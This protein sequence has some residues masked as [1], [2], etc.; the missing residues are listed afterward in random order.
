MV[1]ALPSSLVLL[2]LSALVP[3]AAFGAVD[4]AGQS[5]SP[6]DPFRALGG[7]RFGCWTCGESIDARAAKCKDVCSLEEEWEQGSL[8]E[9]EA[10]DD[11]WEGTSTAEMVSRHD[12]LDE[13]QQGQPI[14]STSTSTGA[15]QP[16]ASAD[17]TPSL[18]DQR[19]GGPTTSLA[20]STTPL[21]ASDDSFLSFEDWKALQL[22]KL[23]SDG[24]SAPAVNFPSSLVDGHPS[25]P[26]PVLPDP[27]ALNQSH[28]GRPSSPSSASS[29]SASSIAVKSLTPSPAVKSPSRRFNYA[30][31]D[32]SARIHFSSS[33]TRSPSAILHKSKDRYMLTPCAAKSHYV[34]IELCDEIRLDT[35]EVGNFEFFSSVVKD[36][37]VRAGESEG[38]GREDEEGWKDLGTFRM[39]NTRGMQ[40]F[41]FDPPTGFHRFLR[42]D[43]LGRYGTEYYCPVS[44]VR[45]YGLNQ[46]E[47]YRYELGREVSGKEAEGQAEPEMVSSTLLEESPHPAPPLND[48]TPN[49]SSSILSPSLAA[50]PTRFNS[51]FSRIAPTPDPSQI[52]DVRPESFSGPSPTFTP[53]PSSQSPSSSSHVRA[54][55]D[56]DQ[57]P[58]DQSSASQSKSAAS[59]SSTGTSTATVGHSKSE[60][61]AQSSSANVSSTSLSS[62]IGSSALGANSSSSHAPT[63]SSQLPSPS[64]S[65]SRQA[66]P[67]S[68]SSAAANQRPPPAPRPVQAHPQTS[69]SGESI[70]SSIVRRLAY[71]ETTSL[72]ATS[73]VEEQSRMVRDVL[74]KLEKDLKRLEGWEREEKGRWAGGLEGLV[75]SFIL[76]TPLIWQVQNT[77]HSVFHLR[78]CSA[79]NKNGCSRRRPAN[80][81]PSGA[82]S[83]RNTASWPTGW[84]CSIRRS[85]SIVGWSVGRCSSS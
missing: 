70:Y 15:L 13:S 36:V 18:E 66:P 19:S 83:R 57:E 44:L 56:G 81:M 24:S 5:C 43:F 58:Y 61:L 42:L 11:V 45:V 12:Q 16:P 79:P 6:A 21:P 2:V 7:E 63:S 26:S 80:G 23:S 72:Y 35:L 76:S 69:D 85:W 62:S 37:R 20:R 17:L 64:P 59:P 78:W 31:L 71:L 84:R 8:P 73:Y 68:S 53:F 41:K 74:V 60:S 4:P 40:S 51:D 67:P 48:S 39:G 75:R 38:E 25:I 47:A 77:D 49:L 22:A 34:V 65:S 33:Q 27:L 10:S 54:S 3:H 14:P 52:T 55:T 82:R 9:G 1:L 50:S 28:D 46:M 30:S 32:C 29:S